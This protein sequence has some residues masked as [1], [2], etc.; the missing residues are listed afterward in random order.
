MKK[1]M[2]YAMLFT[3][4]LIS[5]GS[6]NSNT[7]SDAGNDNASIEMTFN[8]PD[9][10]IQQLTNATGSLGES[11]GMSCFTFKGD[12]AKLEVY[13]N[14]FDLKEQAYLVNVDDITAPNIL[15]SYKISADGKTSDCC[16][17]VEKEST[18]SMTITTIN[19]DIISGNIDVVNY[20]GSSIK[21][22]FSF[23]K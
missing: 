8:M 21:G 13:I 18:G 17:K 14:S 4:T 15:A 16:G 5:C 7:S 3:A 10:E 20:D 1:N 11:Y 12:N 23:A 6:D 19:A 2:F 9:K 22:S